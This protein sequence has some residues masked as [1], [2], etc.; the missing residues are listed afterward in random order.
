MMFY[1]GDL[2]I[3]KFV[4]TMLDIMNSKHYQR[5][6]V[7]EFRFIKNSNLQLEVASTA[8]LR[9]FNNAIIISCHKAQIVYFSS[10]CHEL[11]IFQI[12]TNDGN[13]IITDMTSLQ[14]VSQV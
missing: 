9:Y 12:L 8:M 2:V 7:Y 14:G 5:R 13:T 3:P 10:G 4:D 11:D 6:Y 1:P